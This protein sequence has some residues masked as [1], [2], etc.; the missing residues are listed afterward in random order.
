MKASHAHKLEHEEDDDP[1][2]MSA[3]RFARTPLGRA[4]LH[5]ECLCHHPAAARTDD[6][7]VA[8]PEE[9]PGQVKGPGLHTADI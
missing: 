5:L 1:L 4:I 3:A 7:P 9:P 6:R 8:V 2:R